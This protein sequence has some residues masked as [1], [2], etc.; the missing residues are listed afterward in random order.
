MHFLGFCAAGLR[1]GRENRGYWEEIILN[2]VHVGPK[3][4]ALSLA[5]AGAVDQ[6]AD[7]LPAESLEEAKG[8]GGVGPGR[9]E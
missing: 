3:A 1:D 6:A 8:K 9:G 2:K 7:A 5:A 4:L